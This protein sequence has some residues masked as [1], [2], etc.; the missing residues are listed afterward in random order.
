MSGTTAPRSGPPKVDPE[1]L[2]LKAA[3]R[4]VVRFKRRLLIGIA[5][6]ACVAVFGVT[7][8]ALKGP[9]MRLGQQARELYNTERKPTPEGLASL[10][11][12][13]GQMRTDTPQL[14]PPL[15]GDLGR[16][17][18]ERQRQLGLTP[19]AS[20]GPGRPG[21]AAASC[22]AGTAGARGRRVL[23]DCQ[24]CRSRQ[25]VRRGAGRQR[26]DGRRAS[27]NDGCQPPESRSRAGSEQ[28]AAQARLPESRVRLD[29][30]SLP[31]PISAAL[32]QSED[33]NEAQLVWNRRKAEGSTR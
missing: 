21:R 22:A 26:R 28:P 17:I 4:R 33:R 18:L 9:A 10:P 8:L 32:F 20:R 27:A 7:W 16:P 25:R 12:N 6:T 1:T 19:G 23:P 2:V 13:Y 29:D 15:P 30:P 14:G 31:E 24:P 5:T 11:G 3:P